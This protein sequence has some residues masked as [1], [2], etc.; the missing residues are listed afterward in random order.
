V[1]DNLE[2]GSSNTVPLAPSNLCV[3]LKFRWSLKHHV[4]VDLPF[5]DCKLISQDGATVSTDP[6]QP[7]CIPVSNTYTVNTQVTVVSNNLIFASATVPDRNLHGSASAWRGRADPGALMHSYFSSQSKP[8][9]VYF[10]FPYDPIVRVYQSKYSNYS[11]ATMIIDSASAVPMS[12]NDRQWLL[13]DSQTATFWQAA[14]RSGMAVWGGIAGS[15]GLMTLQDIDG[16]SGPAVA[17]AG[18]MEFTHNPANGRYY[19]VTITNMVMPNGTTP[20]AYYA[21][22]RYPTDTI[23]GGTQTYTIID[24]CGKTGAAT[25]YTGIAYADYGHNSS[26]VPDGT[27]E[28]D[29]VI[30]NCT[31]L[32][33]NT[34]HELY[35]NGVKNTTAARPFGGRIGDPIMSDPFGRLRVEYML[36]MTNWAAREAE[37]GLTT[38][39]DAGRLI[40][41]EGQTFD[42]SFI[43]NA[44]QLFEVLAPNSRAG[45]KLSYVPWTSY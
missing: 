37:L 26:I 9:T 30:I 42:S 45:A 5:V 33:P 20:W 27:H 14:S 44:Y 1:F 7:A 16:A 21:M 23:T 25:G 15:I 28:F 35:V 29:M 2:G 41:N 12:N 4:N 18:K 38:T 36:P 10:A 8:A 3:P 40:L 13:N 17:G 6:I 19:F 24:P 11:N 34:R 31:G 39:P 32:L 22:M 43:G